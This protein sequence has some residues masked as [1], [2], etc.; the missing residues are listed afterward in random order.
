M[1]GATG[2]A[3]LGAWLRALE[4]ERAWSERLRAERK[5]RA[6]NFSDL[7]IVV[8]KACEYPRTALIAARVNSY[9]V[10]TGSVDDLLGSGLPLRGLDALEC[11]RSAHPEHA[12]AAIIEG[13]GG[14][15]LRFRV[16]D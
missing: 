14:S 16:P 9:L 2:A 10:V 3:E 13:P 5:L 15:V 4:S 1:D 12:H 6:C 11:D 7:V 8:A